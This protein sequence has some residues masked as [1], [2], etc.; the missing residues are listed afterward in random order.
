MASLHPSFNLLSEGPPYN[1]NLAMPPCFKSFDSPISLVLWEVPAQACLHLFYRLILCHWSINLIFLAA[2]LIKNS[3][4]S[5]NCHILSWFQRFSAVLS[6]H[7]KVSPN[8]L[9]HNYFVLTDI[10]GK[11]KYTCTVLLGPQHR[12]FQPLKIILLCAMNALEDSTVLCLF[13]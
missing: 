5:W 1:T 13:W 9:K 2:H 11:I 6:L 12:K 10:S 7:L 3:V 8:Q 4:L